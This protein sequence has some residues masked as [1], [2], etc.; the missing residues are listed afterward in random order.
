MKIET[1]SDLI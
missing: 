1:R